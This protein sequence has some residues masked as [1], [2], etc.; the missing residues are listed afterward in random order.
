MLQ[1]CSKWS[2][3]FKWNEEEVEAVGLTPTGRATINTLQLN[4]I[5]LINL[6]TLLKSIGEHPPKETDLNEE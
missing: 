1:T 6:R 4:R 2:T 3:H 5:E